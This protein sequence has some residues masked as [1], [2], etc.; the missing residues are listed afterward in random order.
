MLGF[1]CSAAS[2][3]GL[4]NSGGSDM[5]SS[6]IK[7]VRKAG[8]VV[9]DGLRPDGKR[10]KLV[11]CALNSSHLSPSSISLIELPLSSYSN[12]IISADTITGRVLHTHLRCCH[13]IQGVSR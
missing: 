13:R 9:W 3:D 11:R 1:R 12:D 5:R 6:G 8:G 10:L 7:K 4:A 2:V